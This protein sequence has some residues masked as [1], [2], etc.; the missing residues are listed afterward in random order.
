MDSQDNLR[1]RH[2]SPGH[3][4]R[5]RNWTSNNYKR[6]IVRCA[7][8]SIDTFPWLS[9]KGVAREKA[10][11]IAQLDSAPY[12]RVQR[13]PQHPFVLRSIV[14]TSSPATPQPEDNLTRRA[15]CDH[16]GPGI[17]GEA[18]VQAQ[19]KI[20]KVFPANHCDPGEFPYI[21]VSRRARLALEMRT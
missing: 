13:R 3:P 7:E 19:V 20:C 11:T 10:N 1:S 12:Q 15:F 8:N 21:T 4:I 5:R 17:C 9:P 16:R 2:F 14:Y 18:Q 6:V